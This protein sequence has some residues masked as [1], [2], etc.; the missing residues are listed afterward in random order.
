MTSLNESRG[1]QCDVRLSLKTQEQT[2]MRQAMDGAGLTRWE[3]EA[4]ERPAYAYRFK[5]LAQFIA[6]E[7]AD[8]MSDGKKW[9]M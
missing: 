1:A 3:A 6:G 4:K 5:E 8:C 2:L 9:A 7:P